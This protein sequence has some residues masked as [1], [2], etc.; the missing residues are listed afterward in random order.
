MI[1]VMAYK[2]LPPALER[3]DL[4]QAGVA[5]ALELLDNED[6]FF[7]MVE[8]SCIDD[9]CHANKVGYAMEELF[10]FDRAVGLVLEWAAKNGETLVVVT[11]DHSTGGLTLLDGSRKDQKV[12]VNFSSEGH[13][14]VAMPVYAW[15]PGSEN[16]IGIY[17]NTEVSEKIR[18]LIR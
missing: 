17:E 5:K 8:G 6:G 7:L 18:S 2:E 14:G 1:G 10:D 13:N 15:G 12:A 9:Y 3:E 4:F 16:F 11:G